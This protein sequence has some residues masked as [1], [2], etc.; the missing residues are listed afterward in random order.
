MKKTLL[1]GAAALLLF[2]FSGC[3]DKQHQVKAAD[4]EAGK[5][6]VDNVSYFCLDGVRYIKY[7]DDDQFGVTVKFNKDGSVDTNC[8]AEKR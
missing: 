2:A 1:L 4:I 5:I 8:E 3:S 7:D 6:D